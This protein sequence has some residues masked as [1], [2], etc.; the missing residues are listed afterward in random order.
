MPLLS[1][2]TG[3]R[4]VVAT[5]TLAPDAAAPAAV[6]VEPEPAAAVV[7]VLA[8]VAVSAFLELL[9]ASATIAMPATRAISASWRRRDGWDGRIDGLMGGLLGSRRSARALAVVTDG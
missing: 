9:H 4:L 2:T 1:T 7:V 8:T 6:V 5:A 3:P